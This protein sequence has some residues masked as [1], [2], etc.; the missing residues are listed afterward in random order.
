MANLLMPDW[1]ESLMK[2]K[3]FK[4]SFS[5]WLDPFALWSL[6]VMMTVLP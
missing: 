1:I 5:T 6:R 4:G 3:Y 2:V